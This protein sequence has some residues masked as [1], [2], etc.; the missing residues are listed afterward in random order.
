MKEIF[1]EIKGTFY[2]KGKTNNGKEYEYKVVITRKESG[3]FKYGDHSCHLLDLFNP[4]TGEQI[5]NFGDDYYDTRY[6]G[7]STEKNKWIKTWQDFISRHWVN[8]QEV[9]LL[10]YEEKEVEARG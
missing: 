1:K 4:E 3:A 10:D 2:L 9:K 7:I 5:N 6:D 8:V